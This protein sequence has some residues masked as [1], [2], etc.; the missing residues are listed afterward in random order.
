MLTLAL[1][2]ALAADPAADVTAKAEAFVAAL[3][4]GDYAAASK[5]FTPA[6][7]KA[8]PD[9]QLKAL[10]DSLTKQAGPFAKTLATRTEKRGPYQIVLVT[11]EFTKAKLDVRLSF[12]AEQKI[13]GLSIIPPAPPYQPPAYVQADK[14]RESEVKVGAGT[15]WELPGTLSI[16][17]GDGPFPAVVLVHGS[18]P[19]DRDETIGPNKPFRDIAWGL[20]SQG[21]A[22]LRYDKRTLVYGAKLATV[23]NITVKEETVDDALAAV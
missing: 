3:A 18:G 11:C 4:K 21:I 23:K 10:W 16:P 9:D 15:P 20:A 13:A 17:A 6:V 5:D 2:L 1:V 22:V 19:G 7:R 8:L 12:D 14:F